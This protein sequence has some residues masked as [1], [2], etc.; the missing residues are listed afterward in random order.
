MSKNILAVVVNYNLNDA[1]INLKNILSS[2]FENVI[3]IDSGSDVQPDEFDIKLENV[4]Y[5]GLFN[6][7][8]KEMIENNYEWLFFI[9]SDVSMKKSDVDKL[10]INLDE[11]SE[12]I[13][14]YS[15]SS[16]GQS[17]KHCKNKQSGG[18][19]DVVFVEGFMFAANRKIIEQVYPVDVSI[20]KLGHGV[21]ALKGFLCL[22]NKLRC[23]IDDRL[24]FYHRE[25]T[26]YNT[27]EASKQ[28]IDLMNAQGMS[29]FR[30]LWNTYLATGVDSDE[31]L[32]IYKN[33]IL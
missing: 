17:H 26:G 32:R 1:A 4:G 19:R 16:T 2:K 14:V 9:C 15:P 7:A 10:K 33:K 27:N 8:S 31:T 24:C 6:R 11:L 22:K 23:V 12:D 5:S 18:L 20:N 21:D 28:F 29:Q 25:G 30:E 13:G 3:I